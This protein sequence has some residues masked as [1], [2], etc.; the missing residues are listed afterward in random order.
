MF[1]VTTIVQ[2]NLLVNNKDDCHILFHH[3]YK[4][5]SVV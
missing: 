5:V 2:Y 3:Y 1:L 4:Q